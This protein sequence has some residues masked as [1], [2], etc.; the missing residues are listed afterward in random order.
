MKNYN[1]NGYRGIHTIRVTFMCE[2]YVGHIAYKVG[3]NCKG[4]TLLNTDFLEN[5]TQ[6]DIERYVENDCCFEYN[7][8]CDCFSY[9]LR[10]SDG[11]TWEFGDESPNDVA[12]IVVSIEII[13]YK[14][15]E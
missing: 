15:E 3:G 6:E 13:D 2:D 5:D 8:D 7:E 1:V 10:N 12:N 9:V 11:D 4:A 14:E